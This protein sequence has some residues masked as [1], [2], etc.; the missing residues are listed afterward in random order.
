MKFT[1][2]ILNLVACANVSVAFSPLLQRSSHIGI[3]RY[4]TTAI[5]SS[6]WDEEDED[7]ATED[8]RASFDEAGRSLRDEDDKAKMDEIGDY[9][10]N[11]Q[12]SWTLQ[13]VKTWS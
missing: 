5:F 10:S 2:V 3:S 1:A 8:T 7:V 12:V 6:Q 13:E 4:P 11:P 9:D